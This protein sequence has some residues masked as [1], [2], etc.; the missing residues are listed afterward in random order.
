MIVNKFELHYNIDF[1]LSHISN[2]VNA[3]EYQL[4]TCTEFFDVG[5]KI[6]SAKK[7]IIYNLKLYRFPSKTLSQAA[8]ND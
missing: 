1:S 7:N 6:T 4:F 2:S 5:I 3:D 8:S